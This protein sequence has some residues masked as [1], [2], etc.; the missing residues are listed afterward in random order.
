[1]LRGVERSRAPQPSAM[2]CAE[3]WVNALMDWNRPRLESVTPDR[4][5]RIGNFKDG[6]LPASRAIPENVGPNSASPRV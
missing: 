6:L 2:R 5:S 3:A 1:M 4:S